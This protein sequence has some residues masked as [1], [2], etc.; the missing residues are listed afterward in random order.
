MSRI[1]RSEA[2]ANAEALARR[3]TPFGPENRTSAG[4]AFDFRR[5]QT[6]RDIHHAVHLVR[7]AYADEVPT[8]LH[9]HGLAPDGTPAMTQRTE[10][11]IF[12]GD[13]WTDAGKGEQPLVSYYITP[14]RATLSA[15]ERHPAESTRKRA[16]IVR[17]VAIGG[18]DPDAA[19]LT[20]GVPSWTTRLVAFDALCTFLRQLSDVR[21]DIAKEVAAA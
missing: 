18:Q 9:E 11:F 4:M 21:V 19:A 1:H 10:S 3:S 13:S 14:F 17:H 7:R 6:P 15:M 2:Q 8:R 20:E 12:G 5:R 16:A